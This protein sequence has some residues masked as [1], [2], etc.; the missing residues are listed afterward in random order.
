MQIGHIGIQALCFGYFHLGQQMKVT[1]G[2][3]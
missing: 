2:G 1:A 3:A